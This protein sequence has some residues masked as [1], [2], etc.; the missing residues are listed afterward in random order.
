VEP[1]FVLLHSPA[2]GPLSW[3]PVAREL[4]G[5]GYFV[6]V[7]SLLAITAGDPPF[8]PRVTAA[9]TG[10]LAGVR[11][12]VPVVLVAHSNAGLYVPVVRRAVRQPVAASIFV[13]ASL[14]AEHGTTPV[15]EPEFLAFLRGLAQPDGRL[16]RWTDWWA[17]ADLGL[18]FPDG[19]T[20]AEVTA[21]QPQLPLSYYEQEIPV[22]DGWA[23]HPCGYL[24]FGSTYAHAVA[25]A[26]ARGWPVRQLPGEH[27]HQ[28]VDPRSV[29]RELVRSVL[30]SPV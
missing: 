3:A 7:P 6:V 19:H 16:P 25:Q 28:L 22:P 4:R 17:D 21:E 5:L 13:D 30:H 12:E 27:L 8:W 26:R 20:R 14:P 9:V 24:A 11:A 2:L 23:D 1:V 15:A 29:A 18:L 10:A